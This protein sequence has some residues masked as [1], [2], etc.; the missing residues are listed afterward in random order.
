MRRPFE[1]S[2]FVTPAAAALTFGVLASCGQSSSERQLQ[3]DAG[4]VRNLIVEPMMYTVPDSPVRLLRD[5]DAIEL[6]PAPQ[7]GHVLLVGARVAG[8]E[9]RIIELRARL[10]RHSSGEIVA[11]ERRTVAV[12]PVPEQPALF[13]T[14][15]R[16]R[17]QVAHIA[18]CPDYESV[19][20][21]DVPHALEV[22]VTELDA[23]LSSG[24]ASVNV[25]P[26]CLPGDSG[27][28]AHCRC[29]CSAN[30]R[31]GRCVASSE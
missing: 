3:Q 8:L 2:G 23:E 4:V 1:L 14:D 7:G 20:V 22:T 31:L 11:E 21:V 5:S 13:E 15:R 6:W 29:E 18:A 27:A 9:S 12:E 28:S 30:Y 17:T 16:T 26:R 24:S 10:R 19:D 25:V